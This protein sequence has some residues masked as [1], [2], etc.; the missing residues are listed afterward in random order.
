VE[1]WEYA[2][3]ERSREIELSSFVFAAQR[4]DETLTEIFIGENFELML[5]SFLCAVAKKKIFYNS[6]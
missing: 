1:C 6:I 2:A 3:G 4:Y 5:Q